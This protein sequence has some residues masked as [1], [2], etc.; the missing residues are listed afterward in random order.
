MN[1]TIRNIQT[2][3]NV[4]EIQ[5]FLG[6]VNYLAR[7][8]P[9]VLDTAKPLRDLTCEKNQWQWTEKEQKSFDE[10]KRLLTVQPNFSYYDVN[11]SVTTQ[12]D[13]SNYG[14]GG[15]LLQEGKPIG[16]TSHANV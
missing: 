4:T 7:F 5:R 2:L 13:A 16:F 1:R 9:K 3:K 8:L 14:A 10:T 6:C 11:K 12:C 15:V